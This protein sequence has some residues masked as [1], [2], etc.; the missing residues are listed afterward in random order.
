MDLQTMKNVRPH[1]LPTQSILLSTRL[2][3]YLKTHYYSSREQFLEHFNLIVTNCITYNGLCVDH[4][5]PLP[6]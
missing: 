1:L 4:V 5:I 3:Q 2:V 6:C